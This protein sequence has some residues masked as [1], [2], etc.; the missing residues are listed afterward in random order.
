MKGL[1]GGGVVISL[2]ILQLNIIINIAATTTTT[3]VFQILIKGSG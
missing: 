3:T 2:E 1:F